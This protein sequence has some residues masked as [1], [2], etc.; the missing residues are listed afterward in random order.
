MNCI[1]ISEILS[2]FF[3]PIDLN[4][5]KEKD[6]FDKA[7]QIRLVK[8]YISEI[9]FFNIHQYKEYSK[10]DLI[11]A[12]APTIKNPY[13]TQ[14]DVEYAIVEVWITYRNKID[15][16]KNKIAF[17]IQIKIIK[18]YYKKNT[19]THKKG[20]L[21]I[22]EIKLGSSKLSKVMS[23]LS[24]Y[25]YDGITENIA[26][27]LETEK[28]KSD[29]KKRLF[30]EDIY[31]YLMKFSEERLLKLAY[32]K[33][34]LT[35]KKFNKNKHNFTSLSFSTQSRIKQ[36]IMNRNKNK[37]SKIRAFIT[38]GGYKRESLNKKTQIDIPISISQ[39]YHKNLEN[40]SQVYTIQ[41]I[42]NRFHRVI[43]TAKFEKSIPIAEIKEDEILGIDINIKNNLFATSDKNIEID[44]DRKLLNDYV[45]F[46]KKIDNREKDKNGKT[47]KLGRDNSLKY[48]RWQ[49]RIE[50]MII[51]KIVKLIRLAKNRGYKHLVLEDLELL[52]KLRSNN[53]EFDVNNGRLI[54][55][56]NLSSIKHKIV[57]IT[58][59]YKINISFVH[60]EYTSQTCNICG[61]ISKNNRKT[62][63]VFKCIKC[64]YSQ[65]ADFNSAH[66][67]KDRLLLD[68]LRV[69][70]L[71]NNNFQEF[72]T[73]KLNR[74]TLKSILENYYGVA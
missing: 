25:G 2:K 35:F 66:N 5:Q 1:K 33:R 59:K 44:H 41:F 61:C 3:Y 68:V 6:I 45:K 34:F 57:N 73:K 60:P 58:H 46:L 30:Y 27:N 7:F 48:N 71:K 23:F 4:A 28:Y 56:L 21:R 10:N 29:S 15:L 43:L 31:K 50:N 42:E 64:N 19:K 9:I 69:K 22:Y 52:D 67:I 55:L 40:Y 14:K 18:K 53:L 26:K 38:V 8:N 74:A 62:Q 13:L 24:R 72:R 12:L 49:N 51:S 54:R 37:T 36:L 39:N 63:E 32:K 17:K 47:K 20:D 70:T 16:I 65:N 11:K